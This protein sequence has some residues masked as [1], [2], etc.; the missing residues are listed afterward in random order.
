MVANLLCMASS[1]H[2]CCFSASRLLGRPDRNAMIW[3]EVNQQD[4][5]RLFVRDRD[6]IAFRTNHP[7]DRSRIADCGGADFEDQGIFLDLQRNLDGS[8]RA[9]IDQEPVPAESQAYAAVADR[10]QRAHI[11]VEGVVVMVP[12][13]MNGRL[14]R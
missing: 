3:C 9:Q 10:V 14:R 1:F 6:R 11:E 12:K 2:F 5:S 4:A 13:K 8:E 7:A